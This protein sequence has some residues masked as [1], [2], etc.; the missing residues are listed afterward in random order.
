MLWQ[1]YTLELGE[2]EI[3]PSRNAIVMRGLNDG[4]YFRLKIDQ[5]L[6]NSGRYEP[7][8]INCRFP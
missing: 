1:G 7:N 4:N 3:I 5:A 8:E 6:V 2:M